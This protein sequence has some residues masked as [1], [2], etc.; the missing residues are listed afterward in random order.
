M[1]PALK[2]SPTAS[3]SRRARIV[4]TLGPASENPEILAG[5]LDAGMDVARLNFSHGTPREQVR[6][7]RLLRRLTRERGKSVELRRG[8]E[9]DSNVLA[10]GA[11]DVY[12]Q[13]FELP[14]R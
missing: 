8:S 13:R 11:A 9:P 6:R 2:R 7:M 14:R 5:L 4:C 1:P 10:E 12:C 3:D